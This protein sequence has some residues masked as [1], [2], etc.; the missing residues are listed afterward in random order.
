MPFGPVHTLLHIPQLRVRHAVRVSQA[1]QCS[2]VSISS[3]SVVRGNRGS[4]GGREWG[5]LRSIIKTINI[6]I[7]IILYNL[8]LHLNVT[9]IVNGHHVACIVVIKKRKENQ[10]HSQV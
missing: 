10:L 8:Y 4:T 5:L 7:I 3:V 9:S 6:N 1:V 2:G